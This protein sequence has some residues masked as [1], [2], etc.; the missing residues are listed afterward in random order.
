MQLNS[1][2]TIPLVTVFLKIDLFIVFGVHFRILNEVNK[3]AEF[4]Y[5]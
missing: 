2:L 3:Q 1:L 5:T 4:I